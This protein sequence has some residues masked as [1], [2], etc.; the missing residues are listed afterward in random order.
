MTMLETKT[1]EVIATVPTGRGVDGVGYDPG[2][3][4]P[5][6][7]TGEGTLTVVRES[8]PR[9]FEV[10]QTVSTQVGARTMTIDTKTHNI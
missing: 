1:G 10:V 3:G 9:H 8:G 5:S 7:S 2:A 6:N 4:L